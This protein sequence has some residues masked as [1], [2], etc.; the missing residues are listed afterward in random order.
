MTTYIGKLYNGRG[1]L[2]GGGLQLAADGT[3]AKILPEDENTQGYVI[4]GVIDIHCHGGGERRSQTVPIRKQSEPQSLRISKK[5]R[6]R[7]LLHLFR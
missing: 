6:R 3:V 7:C 5:V 2:V 4:P 1:E